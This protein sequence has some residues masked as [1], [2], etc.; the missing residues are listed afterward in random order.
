[1][2]II[3]FIFSLTKVLW[4]FVMDIKYNS[5]HVSYSGL[6]RSMLNK[7]MVT[8]DGVPLA[9]GASGRGAPPFPAIRRDLGRL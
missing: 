5:S 6:D 7:K 1:M 4:K 8:D 9:R 3:F 2:D